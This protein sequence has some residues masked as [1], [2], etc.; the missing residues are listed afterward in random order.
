MGLSPGLGHNFLNTI[1]TKH[2][3]F[4]LHG[5]RTL[6]FRKSILTA[7]TASRV[8]SSF[9][10]YRASDGREIL[11]NTARSERCSLRCC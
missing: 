1:I 7:D 11:Y 5:E 9:F 10:I 8:F 4:L 2:G 3:G 6:H